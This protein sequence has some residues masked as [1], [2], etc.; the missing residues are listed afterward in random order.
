MTSTQRTKWCNEPGFY[1]RHETP[2]R[3]GQGFFVSYFREKLSY[4]QEKLSCPM[5]T[6]EKLS[7]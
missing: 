2:V 5:V 4:F 7:L 6:T 1:A 3:N